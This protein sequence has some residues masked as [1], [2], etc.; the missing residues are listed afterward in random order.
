MSLSVETTVASVAPAIGSKSVPLWTATPGVVVY[1]L[2]G[3]STRTLVILPLG[4]IPSTGSPFATIGTWP[5]ACLPFGSDGRSNSTVGIVYPVPPSVIATASTPPD[6][7]AVAPLPPPPDSATAKP[8]YPAPA[9]ETVN[10][11]SAPDVE[12][13]AVAVAVPSPPPTVTV[14][15]V[16]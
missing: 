15:A 9:A 2:P 12:I 13:A 10:P 3:S 4:S 5:L 8:E 1:P 11:V 7:V 14:G 6:A 16:V